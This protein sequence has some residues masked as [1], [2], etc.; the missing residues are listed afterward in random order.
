MGR[1]PKH[2]NIYI[3]ANLSAVQFAFILSALDYLL[4]DCFSDIF[5]TI[6]QMFLEIY[7]CRG[8]PKMRVR[9][10]GQNLF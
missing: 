10:F 6:Q 3:L 7:F 1:T 4:R 2:L 5:V 9:K 8:L